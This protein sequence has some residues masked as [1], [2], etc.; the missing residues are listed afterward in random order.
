MQ[1]LLVRICQTIILIRGESSSQ[2]GAVQNGW[3]ASICACNLDL[4][5]HVDAMRFV[6]KWLQPQISWTH[7]HVIKT[8]QCKLWLHPH[9]RITCQKRDQPE[10]CLQAH[11]YITFR[12]CDQNVISHVL[13]LR[14]CGPL[15]LWPKRH[16]LPACRH[17]P[18]RFPE[19]GTCLGRLTV[20]P[21]VF[22]AT[23][24]SLKISQP[25]AERKQK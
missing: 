2:L 12:S 22:W 15:V 4:Y 18:K 1:H 13:W 7:S 20:N 16:F 8:G 10:M 23:Y 3:A 21:H 5:N 17:F 19:Q 6:K 14:S 11:F 9:F 24:K 25:E